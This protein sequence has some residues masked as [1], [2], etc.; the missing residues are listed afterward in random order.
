MRDAKLR[1]SNTEIEN[2]EGQE[3]AL[4][5]PGFQIALLLTLKPAN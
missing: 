1:G 4:I 2:D 3:S 5:I